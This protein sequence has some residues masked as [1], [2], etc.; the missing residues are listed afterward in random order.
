MLGPGIFNQPP[1]TD[2]KE[3]LTFPFWKHIDEELS[4]FCFKKSLPLVITNKTLRWTKITIYLK[5]TVPHHLKEEV[6]K[7]I[8]ELKKLYP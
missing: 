4:K 3:T 6:S 2:I 8:E 5:I 1:Q 7:F